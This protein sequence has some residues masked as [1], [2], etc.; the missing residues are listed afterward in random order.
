MI[1]YEVKI[2]WQDGKTTV[3]HVKTFHE[4]FEMAEVL[5]GRQEVKTVNIKTNRRDFY[6]QAL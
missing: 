5:Y 2:N 6:G 4:A 1:E 3:C